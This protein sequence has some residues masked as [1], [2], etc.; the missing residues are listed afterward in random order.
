[1]LSD[2]VTGN[3]E[4]FFA[5]NATANSL[6][7]LTMTAANSETFVGASGCALGSRQAPDPLLPGLVVLAALY[8]W[9]RRRSR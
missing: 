5:N 2:S 6:V 9:R 1:M 4:L 8:L 3:G 7:R